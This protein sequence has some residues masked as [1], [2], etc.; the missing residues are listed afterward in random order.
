MVAQETYKGKKI[1]V[2]NSCGFGYALRETAKACEVHCTTKR[3]CSLEIIK[4]A[5]RKGLK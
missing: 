4:H 1:F 5:V 2:C 3:S